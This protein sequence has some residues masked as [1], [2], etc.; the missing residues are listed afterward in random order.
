MPGAETFD[1][2]LVGGI[3]V[4]RIWRDYRM[5]LWDPQA[6]GEEYVLPHAYPS[7]SNPFFLEEQPYVSPRP[8]NTPGLNLLEH[9]ENTFSPVVMLGIA[10]FLTSLT[11]YRIFI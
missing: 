7:L 11:S 2:P 8:H 6:Q 10:K 1:D 4:D 3:T 9:T 5:Y